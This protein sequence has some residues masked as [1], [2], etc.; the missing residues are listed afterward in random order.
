MKFFACVIAALALASVRGAVLFEEPSPVAKV[1]K[2]VED[3]KA[4][5][6]NEATAE[7]DEYNKFACVV[8]ETLT[9]KAAAISDAQKQLEGLQTSVEEATG[10]IAASGAEIANLKKQIEENTQ[11][12]TDTSGQCQSA[13]KEYRKSTMEAESAMHALEAGIKTLEGAGSGKKAFLGTLQQAQLVGVAAGLRNV[14]GLPVITDIASDDDLEVVRRFVAKP[15][16]FA[17]EDASGVSALQVSHAQNPFGDFAPKHDNVGGILKGLYDSIASSMEK[18]SAEQANK[19]KSCQ[20]LLATKKKELKSLTTTLEDRELVHG[21]NS[22]K[23]GEDR[24]L[25]TILTEQLQ[26]DEDVFEQTK[27]SGQ[28][29]AAR[30]SLRTKERTQELKNLGSAI[31]IL[32]DGESTFKSSSVSFMQLDSRGFPTKGRSGLRVQ[33]LGQ[34]K[35]RGVQSQLKRAKATVRSKTGQLNGAIAKAVDKMI[36]MLHSEAAQDIKERDL[37][38]EKNTSNQVAQ[39]DSEHAA[40]IAKAKIEKLSAEIDALKDEITTKDTEIAHSVNE[41]TALLEERN[42]AQ[43]QFRQ[44]LKMDHDALSL[45]RKATAA[46]QQSRKSQGAKEETGGVVSALQMISE[47]IEKEIQTST[48]AEQ[49]EQEEYATMAKKMHKTLDTAREMKAKLERDVVNREEE[50]DAQSD[51]QVTAEADNSDAKKEAVAIGKECAW[52]YDGSFE[53]RHETREA[54]LA[55]LEDAKS[56]LVGASG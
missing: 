23:L 46:L 4:K 14:I 1:V 48:E 16:D 28:Q 24:Q 43:E 6:E 44:A 25:Q 11:S 52:V 41:S 20:E 3:I 47:D 39:E 22:E 40:H 53:K 33:S 5:V 32:K 42:T 9:E 26:N 21:Q 30:W 31:R 19:E 56:S 55:E 12:T 35:A 45:L 13:K 34:V 37:C 38:Q 36:A 27:E 54:E 17:T 51:A 15:R 7:Q 2:L 10:K 50:I 18:G 49:A 29:T 8:E